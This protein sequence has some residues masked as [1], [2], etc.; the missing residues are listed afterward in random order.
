MDGAGPHAEEVE[1]TPVEG[2]SAPHAL[3]LPQAAR[4]VL[5][6]AAAFM[7]FAIVMWWW[8]SLAVLGSPGDWAF[9]F[10]QFWQGAN[11]VVNGV[12]P[13]PSSELLETAGYELDPAGIQEVFRF[14]YPA[15]AAV[16]LV[17]LGALGFETAA[18]VW[19]LLLIVSLTAA[20]L[21]LGVRDWRVYAVA[22]S[23]APVIS[24]VR[25]G[26]LTPVLILALAI[27]WRWRDHRGVAGATL[28]VAIALKLFVWP[29]VIWLAATRRWFEAGLAFAVAVT[30]TF[31]AWAAIGFDG[32][33]QYPELLRRLA[34][35]VADRGYSLVALGVELGLPLGAA[36]AVPWL[37][38]VAL[39]LGVVIAAR[40]ADGD[41]IAFTLA[42]GAT[43]A[44][45]PI[46]WLHYFALLVVPLAVFRPRFAWVWLLLW[47][48]WL[49]PHQ[50]SDG[51]LWRIALALA[52]A[53]M[54]LAIPLRSPRSRA[55]A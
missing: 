7:L 52:I 40:R 42:V 2:G 55:E 18:T 17:P 5:D 53:S 47:V 26:T 12:S 48:F 35:V 32:L 24:S 14:P 3:G 45:S 29:V 28:G 8:F 23:S 41:Q 44:L 37:A 51:D 33:A 22:A 43:I 27:A 50:T 49:T 11:D 19:S 39:I 15:G 4:R 46:V 54:L 13:Y 10:R 31:G 6:P 25:L 38:G 16:A 34:D 36:D 1:A 20:Q 21:L 30:L 9:D